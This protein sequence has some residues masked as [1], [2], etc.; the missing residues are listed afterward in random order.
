MKKY[1]SVKTC[2]YVLHMNDKL[3][4][5]HNSVCCQW[6]SQYWV[7]E[8]VVATWTW[9]KKTICPEFLTSQWN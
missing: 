7:S 1:K 4:T 8:L 5:I 2:T 3:I 6:M 9:K